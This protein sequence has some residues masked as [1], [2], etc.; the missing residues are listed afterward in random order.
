MTSEIEV[1]DL[2][3]TP[4]LATMKYFGNISIVSNFEQTTSGSYCHNVR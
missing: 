4:Q 1:K 2:A 3:V